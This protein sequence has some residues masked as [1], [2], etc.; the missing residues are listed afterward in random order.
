MRKILKMLWCCWTFSLSAIK[1]TNLGV[2]FLKFLQYSIQHPKN[3]LTSSILPA[4]TMSA[5]TSLATLKLVSK[6]SSGYE[7]GSCVSIQY[8]V[9]TVITTNTVLSVLTEKSGVASYK[10]QY[11]TNRVLYQRNIQEWQAKM[12]TTVISRVLLPQ[13]SIVAVPVGTDSSASQNCQKNIESAI[14]TQ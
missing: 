1:Y 10:R 3:T 13:S 5:G 9:K 6:L 12:Q 4:A 7:V 11:Y 8:H 14:F 2:S